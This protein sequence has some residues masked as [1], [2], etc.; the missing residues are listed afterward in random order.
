MEFPTT[1]EELLV[2]GYVFFCMGLN[3]ISFLISAFYQKKGGANAPYLGFL[4]SLLLGAIFIGT[5]LLKNT[6]A[7]VDIA[8]ATALLGCSM[9]S[10]LSMIGLF[11]SMR[12]KRAR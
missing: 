1:A 9:C 11:M 3:A 4:F 8:R 5:F 7:Y 6:G 12:R 2:A 10:T